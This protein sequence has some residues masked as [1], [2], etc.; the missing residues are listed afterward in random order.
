MIIMA[1]AAM[2]ADHSWGATHAMG[3]L[4]LLLTPCLEYGATVS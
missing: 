2:A 3:L 1:Q 4:L